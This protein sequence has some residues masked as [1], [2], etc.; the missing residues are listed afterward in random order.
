MREWLKKLRIGK[1]LTQGETA[2]LLFISQ[3]YYSKIERGQGQIDITLLMASKISN[4]FGVSLEHIVDLELK[5]E[6]SSCIN[7]V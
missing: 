4:L 6:S 3:Q 2:K 1:G 5:G 7:G